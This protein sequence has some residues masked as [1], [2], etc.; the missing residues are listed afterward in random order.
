MNVDPEIQTLNG[1]YNLCTAK[2]SV[3]KGL[4]QLAID[5]FRS[6]NQHQSRAIGRSKNPRGWSWVY[7]VMGWYNLPPD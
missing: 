6:Q 4:W 1:L 2:K 7:L 5:H 3:A